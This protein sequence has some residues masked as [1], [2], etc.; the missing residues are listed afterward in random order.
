MGYQYPLIRVAPINDTDR[1]SS[2]D[3]DTEG[4]EY[5]LLVKM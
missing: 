1:L 4:L 2:A 5:P 3:K